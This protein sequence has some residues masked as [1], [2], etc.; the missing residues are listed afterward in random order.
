MRVCGPG[1]FCSRRKNGRYKTVQ[2]LGEL[3]KGLHER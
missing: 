3:L 1:I 2:N